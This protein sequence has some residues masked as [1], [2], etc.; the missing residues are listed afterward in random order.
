GVVIHVG[1]DL[2]LLRVVLVQESDGDC[3]HAGVITRNGVHTRDVDRVQV[4]EAVITHAVDL[5]PTT[6]HLVVRLGQQGQRL[7]AAAVL[8]VG[9]PAGVPE[10][11]EVTVR[12]RRVAEASSLL[13]VGVLDVGALGNREHHVGGSPGGTLPDLVRL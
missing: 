3:H 12:C 10:A 7:V 11:G 5:L 6:E 13:P 1:Q 8:D 9:V 4:D 2:E